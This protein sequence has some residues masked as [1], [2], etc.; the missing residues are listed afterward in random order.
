MAIVPVSKGTGENR[1]VTTGKVTVAAGGGVVAG[2]S[3]AVASYFGV[4]V[5]GVGLQ[6][7]AGGAS[8]LG[9]STLGGAIVYNVV[10]ILLPPVAIGTG[11][12]VGICVGIGAGKAIYNAL[13]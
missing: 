6:S 5:G 9:P 1:S 2:V 12:V 8:L 13:R 10:G 11:L 4:V 7:M 3:S